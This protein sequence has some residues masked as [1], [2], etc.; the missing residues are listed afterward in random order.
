[1]FSLDYRDYGH[2]SERLGT[3]RANGRRLI[4]LV[5]EAPQFSV[6]ITLKERH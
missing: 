1:V 5:A 3:G 4:A 2:Q 6:V